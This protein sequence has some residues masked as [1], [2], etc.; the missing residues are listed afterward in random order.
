MPT[1]RWLLPLCL[2]AL[3][4]CQLVAAPTPIPTSTDDGGKST[5]TGSPLELVVVDPEWG[6]DANDGGSAASALRTLASARDRVRLMLREQPRSIVVDLLPGRH[7]VPRGGLLLDARDSPGA[8]HS[9][10]WRGV[11]GMTSV[12]G[13][14]PVSGWKL[15]N[16]PALPKGVYSAP[17]PLMPPGPPPPPPPPPPGPPPPPSPPPSPGAGCTVSL[18]KQESKVKCTA[19]QSYGCTGNATSAAVWVLGGCRGQFM[20]N[21][22]GASHRS[23]ECASDAARKATCPC[24]KQQ[25]QQQQQQQQRNPLDLGGGSAP[26][27]AS[28]RHLFVDGARAARTRRNATITLP[29]LKLD[30]FPECVACSYSVNSTDALTWSNPGD[31]E[32]VYSLASWSEPRCTV[33]SVGPAATRTGEESPGGTRLTMKQCVL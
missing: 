9:V 26:A 24:N 22:G 14:E 20:C 18:T 32:F 31:V 6:N 4:W 23:F 11:P 33:D 8:G 7:R 10:E 13:G 28:A 21:G 29:G 5:T 27:P 25:Q 12:S 19:G 15:A 3:A 16:D 1:L 17:A 2:G 30:G